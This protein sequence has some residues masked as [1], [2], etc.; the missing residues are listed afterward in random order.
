MAC[1]NGRN[2]RAGRDVD[3]IRKIHRSK[4]GLVLCP[5]VTSFGRN[6]VHRMDDDGVLSSRGCSRH[7]QSNVHSLEH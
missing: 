7:V 1:N 5:R 3:V 6:G 2:Y 4:W